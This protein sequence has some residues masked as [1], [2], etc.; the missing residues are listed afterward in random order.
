MRNSQ[1]LNCP[2]N[3][4]K[5]TKEYKSQLMQN[6]YLKRQSKNF[7]KIVEKRFKDFLKSIPHSVKKSN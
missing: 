5:N 6:I 3:Y 1:R 7:D 2:K 4:E